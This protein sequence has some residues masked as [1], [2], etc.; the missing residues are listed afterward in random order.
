MTAD[1]FIHELRELL[2]QYDTLYTWVVGVGMFQVYI[3]CYIKGG[4]KRAKIVGN[5][6]L[7]IK[8]T[9]HTAIRL[10]DTDIIKFYP[11]KMIIDN[12]GWATRTTHKR[13]NQWLP[14]RYKAYQ[15]NFTT[16][17]EDMLTRK[18]WEVTEPVTI[19]L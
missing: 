16:I 5:N 4:E 10:H 2:D 12:G 14:D 6:T 11:D 17:I 7:E 18:T 8:Y 3:G 9:D 19:S 1:Q 13:L 15:K